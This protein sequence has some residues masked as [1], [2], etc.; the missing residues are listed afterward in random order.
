M[1]IEFYREG[2]NQPVKEFLD[3]LT[4]KERAK[5]IRNLE[6]LKEFELN[7]GAR[8]I[9]P[10][11]GGLFSLRT[12]FAGNQIRILFFTIIGNRAVLLS[13]FKKKTRKIPGR[14]ITTALKRKE[15]YLRNRR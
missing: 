5:V 3:S 15:N 1:I 14:E 8:Y 7:A 9:E 13:G 12:V 4:K 10:I 2:K 6:L 11:G